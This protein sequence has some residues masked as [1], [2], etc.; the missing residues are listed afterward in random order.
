MGH[1]HRALPTLMIPPIP[2]EKLR[3]CLAV[4]YR[5][6]SRARMLGYEGQEAGLPALRA[7]L[8]ADLMDA[9]H[10]I[11]QVL[12]RW[13]EEVHEPLLRDML[14]G[15]DEKW[16]SEGSA[17]GAAFDRALTSGGA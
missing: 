10:N 9:V 11:P 1:S 17:L 5:A 7:E 14:D 8:L 13:R 6:C 2:E 4:L 3:A 16:S 12:L 15:F